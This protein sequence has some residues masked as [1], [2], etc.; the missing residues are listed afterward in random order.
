MSQISHSRVDGYLLCRRKD[1]YGYTLGLKRI[2]ESDSLAYGSAVHKILEIFYSEILK[3]GG[4]GKTSAV[5]KKQRGAFGKAA[6]KALDAVKSLYTEGYEDSERFPNLKRTM[7][8]YFE[9]AEPFV[10]KG[11]RILAVEKSFAIEYDP[12]TK[13]QFGFVIDLIVEDKDGYYVIVDHKTTYDFYSDEAIAIQGQ[14][15][16]Y[17]GAM[18]GLGYK[19][20]YGVYNQIRTRPL[21]GSKMLKGELVAAL[22]SGDKHETD[23]DIDVPLEK[24]KVADLE[25]LAI[26]HGIKTRTEPE[27][28]TLFQ[29]IDFRA[30]AARVVRTFEEQIGVAAE[31]QARELLPVEV[32]EKSAYRTANKMVCQSCSFK[33]LCEAD[34]RGDNTAMLI[35]TEF[36]KKKK[37]DKIKVSED[38]ESA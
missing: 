36:E 21:M 24:M 4:K 35:Q 6:L 28:E 7:E 10:K 23:Y 33:D 34:L 14:I 13:S 27:I 12:D 18:R 31:I 16:K 15:P 32:I 9:E 5:I 19:V 38:A 8:R 1:Y 22:L 26:N 25:E 29:T 11:F 3:R 17:I 37:R 2:S 20:S 30:S